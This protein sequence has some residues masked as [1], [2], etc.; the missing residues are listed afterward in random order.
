MK[1][2]V[3]N[4]NDWMLSKIASYMRD[5]EGCHV[6]TIE[7]TKYGSRVILQDSFGFRYEVKIETLGRVADAAQSFFNYDGEDFHE[8]AG[9]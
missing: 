9:E 3:T 4:F 5:K 1:A 6:E 8:A 7:P 2:S